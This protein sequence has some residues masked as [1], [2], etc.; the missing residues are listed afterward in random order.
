MARRQVAPRAGIIVDVCRLHGVWFDGGEFERFTEF[1]KAGG[2]EVTRYDATA[3]AE[4]RKRTDLP[5]ESTA[6]VHMDNDEFP[7]ANDLM[8]FVRGLWRWRW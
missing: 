6:W 4:T 5:G 8:R 7:I 3:S 2:L 1:V